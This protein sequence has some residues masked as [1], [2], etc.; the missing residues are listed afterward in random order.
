M[1]LIEREKNGILQQNSP[2]PL[3]SDRVNGSFERMNGLAA[4]RIIARDT[5]GDVN[6]NFPNGWSFT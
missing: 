4:V 5:A 2:L 6:S 3:C 1:D